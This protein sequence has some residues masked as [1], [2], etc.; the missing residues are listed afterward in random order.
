M[1]KRKRRREQPGNDEVERQRA[2]F[3]LRSIGPL[4]SAV[5]MAPE[6]ADI[7]LKVRWDDRLERILALGEEHEEIDSATTW[8]GWLQGDRNSCGVVVE[9][10]AFNVTVVLYFDL[11]KSAIELKLLVGTQRMVL[12]PAG[13][14]AMTS[15]GIVVGT[16][17]PDWLPELIESEVKR[18]V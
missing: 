9:W 18:R 13:A 7:Y 16:E 2:E 4:G 14:S 12:I 3:A 15:K 5:V 10:P 1:A 11:V 6:G 8:V 17:T